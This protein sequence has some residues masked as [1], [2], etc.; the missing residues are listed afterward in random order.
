VT[1][2]RPVLHTLLA[3]LPF[4]CS[5]L[6]GASAAA[7]VVVDLAALDTSGGT[8]QRIHGHTGSGFRGLPVAGGFDCNDD[9]HADL[10]LA[11]FLASPL[12]RLGAGEVY[13]AFGDGTTMGTLD[14]GVAQARVLR[15]LGVGTAEATGSEVWMDDVTGDGLG[16]LLIARQN[17]DPGGRPG[18]GALTILV[19]GPELDD[20]AGDLQ[21][22]DLAAPPAEL[23]LATLVGP[24]QCQRLGMWVR[25]GDVT[26]DGV[27]DIVVGADQAGASQSHLGSAWVVRGGAHLATLGTLD[28]ADFGT[29]P[30][31][32]DLARILP[33]SGSSD[34]IHFGAT[35]QIGDLDGNGRGEVLVAAALNRSGG[36]VATPGCT[37]HGSSCTNPTCS[38]VDGTLYI[39]WDD[40]F[41]DDPW[42]A[43]FE[44]EMNDAPGTTTRINGRTANQ[45]FGE[46]LLAG[47]DWDDDG[48]P[49]LF[50][51]DIVGD[52][53]PGG[54]RAGSGSGFVFYAA[55]S[56]AGVD[57]DLQSP[58]LGLET[59]LVLGASAGDIA[60]DTVAA[61]DFDGDGI[62]DLGIASPHRS[63]LGRFHAGAW[64]VLF[65]L[66]DPWPGTIDLAA[67]PDPALVRITQVYGAEGETAGNLGD[68]LG[69]SAA[70]GDLDG[71]GRF[72]LISNEMVGDGFGGAP[73]DVGNLVVISGIA[74]V[75]EPDANLLAL[76]GVAVLVGLRAARSRTARAR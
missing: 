39:A 64:H 68:T 11:S 29:T 1:I 26:G 61:G 8:L 12:G 42:D 63:P 18:A 60:T 35:V 71:D 2:A 48:N 76:V 73:V 4:A 59:T 7:D 53:S 13:L 56:L 50:V 31:E 9:G 32:G 30:I 37:A 16:D 52:L 27:A 25:T 5:G 47:Y 41:P 51:G 58:P 14:T 43:G 36:V 19:G 28:L 15:I 45:F 38:D 6:L 49:D 10:A 67:L 17:F 34:H 74:L 22:L 66:S 40:N 55:E 46:E 33:P 24:S 3:V 75:P 65:G 72:D 70:A 20:F 57:F 23:T 54:L 62:D 44:F 21:P 69:Y